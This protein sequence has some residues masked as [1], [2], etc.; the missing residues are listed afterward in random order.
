M[1]RDEAGARKVWSRLGTVKANQWAG[2]VF[3]L[4]GVVFLFMFY[5]SYTVCED[6]V[7]NSGAVSRVCRHTQISDP[8]VVAIG[9][10]IITGLG[11]IFSEVSG[12][13]VTLKRQ[14][15]KASH[16][17]SEAKEQSQE[18]SHDA[19]EAKRQSQE[20]F[21]A[22]KYS[23][24]LTYKTASSERAAEI[25]EIF[26]EM[27][28]A[29]DEVQ[30]FDVLAHL[31]NKHDAGMRFTGYAYVSR[32]PDSKWIPAFIR[33]IEEE[34][35]PINEEVALRVLKEE[36][37]KDNCKYLDDDF[38]KTLIARREKYNAEAAGKG[39]KESNRA[40]II[41]EILSQCPDG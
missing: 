15:D 18:A 36:I 21:L 41:R 24:I 8:P 25:N 10:I 38:R 27:Q 29:V 37:L 16:D 30:D 1:S 11:L 32:H 5:L 19:S 2:W 12:F 14:I 33:S 9:L 6:R 4:F 31:G 13:G 40:R 39:E 17:A 35:I 3:I 7:S 34:T 22:A 20:A 23:A 28:D 26:G